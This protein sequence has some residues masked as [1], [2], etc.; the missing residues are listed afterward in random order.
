[1]KIFDIK[2]DINNKPADRKK[3]LEE[4]SKITNDES[5]F[6]TFSFLYENL[7]IIDVKSSSLLTYNSLII[8][9]LAI[10][11]TMRDKT[12]ALTF[13]YILAILF[14]IISSAMLLNVVYLHWSSTEDLLDPDQHLDELLQLREK[15]TITYRKAWHFSFW[16]TIYIALL[17]LYNVIIII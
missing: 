15:R 6:S 1:M 4:L 16:N 9:G 2:R 8:T 17:I 10:V 5:K 11:I 3:H 14:F 7:N 13:L 12:D